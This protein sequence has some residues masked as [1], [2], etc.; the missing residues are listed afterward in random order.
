MTD[1]TMSYHDLPAAGGN[2]KY[3]GRIAQ[4][5]DEKRQKSEKWQ[6]EQDVVQSMLADLPRGSWVL[7]A[8]C[9]TGRFVEFCRNKG[10]IYR[11]IDISQDMIAQAVAKFGNQSPVA[12]IEMQ[13]GEVI[14]TPQLN[15]EQRD[16]LNSGLPDKAVDAALNIRI[17]RWLSP[18]QCQQLFREMQRIVRDRIILTARIANHPHARP[19]ELF[20]AAL[21]DNWA[22]ERDISGY[23][24]DYRIF[25]F[26]CKASPFLRQR[27][28]D[29]VKTG[30]DEW[31]MPPYE[32]A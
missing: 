7:D 24:P 1:G 23:E 9:G 14:E 5:Y 11:G 4:G 32:A 31:T 16:V 15:I 2:L 18:D 30:A 26:R 13:N 29:A 27:E 20:E 21:Y 3:A 10:F 6:V 22:L 25:Q 19:L 12:R 28:I 8:P 17:T